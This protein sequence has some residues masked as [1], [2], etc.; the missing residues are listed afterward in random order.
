[1]SEESSQ[2]E[3]ERGKQVGTTIFGNPPFHPPGKSFDMRT[4]DCLDVQLWTSLF[5]QPEDRPEV[6]LEFDKHHIDGETLLYLL[7]M[8]F[9]T[10]ESFNLAICPGMLLQVLS[11]ALKVNITFHATRGV[12]L[13]DMTFC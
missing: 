6:F 4:W 11:N 2:S 8:N 9:D 10:V 1:M 5:L 13:R 7:N 3:L 12:R